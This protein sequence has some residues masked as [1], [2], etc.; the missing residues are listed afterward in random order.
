MTKLNIT[1]FDDRD[2]ADST[3]LSAL[4][5][6]YHQ[7]SNQLPS[8]LVV[9]ISQAKRYFFANNEVMSNYRGIPIELEKRADETATVI[10]T[11]NGIMAGM[12]INRAQSVADVYSQ[13]EN[14]KVKL[15]SNR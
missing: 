10:K 2:L 3:I 4:V 15:E 7:K 5:D 14:M 8:A 12:H 9:T 1:E 6:C 11:I 13:L